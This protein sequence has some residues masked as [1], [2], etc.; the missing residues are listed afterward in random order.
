[1]N[2]VQK[3]VAKVFGI[4]KH[5]EQEIAALA[6]SWKEQ[7]ERSAAAFSEI[8]ADA[9]AEIDGLRKT[10]EILA[11]TNRE[12]IAAAK[13]RNEKMEVLLGKTAA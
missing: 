9:E 4:E 2:K 12:L 3:F 11:T 8:L 6:D 10:N 7:R 13:E 1:M 5:H